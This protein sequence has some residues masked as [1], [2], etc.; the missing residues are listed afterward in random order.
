MLVVTL[1]FTN[2]KFFITIEDFRHILITA[3]AI[4]VLIDK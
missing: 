4:C 1:L 3:T 2:Y